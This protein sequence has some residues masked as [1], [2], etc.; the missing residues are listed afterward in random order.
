MMTPTKEVRVRIAPSPTGFFHIG[1]AR[2]ALF[3]WLF[4][5]KNGGKF[6]L[7][8]EDTDL[9]RSDPKYE[10]DIISS[11]KWL[12]LDWDEGP[13]RQSD[14][15][16]IYEKHINKLLQRSLVYYCFCSKEDLEI[17]RE[18]QLSQGIPP[19]YS[20]RC[21]NLSAEEVKERLDKNTPSVLRL[22]VPQV[23]ITFKDII[24][25][26]VT[27]NSKLIGDVVVAKDKR[28][29][30]YNLAVVIDD[31]EMGITHVI[32][33]E[34]HL[35]N[36]PKQII[37]QEALEFNRPKYAHLPLI[38]DPNRSKMSKRFQA[39]AIG[40]Y[41]QDYLP[42]AFLNFLLL[43]GWH[44]EDEKEIF[45]K[46]EMIETFNLERVQKGGAI[47][48]MEKLRWLNSQYI[49]KA[50]SGYLAD[51][52]NLEPTPQNIKI[53]KL[54]QQRMAILNE[55]KDI[56]DFFFDLPEYS[57]EL[58]VWK[59]SSKEK[60]LE[61]LKTIYN[62]GEDFNEEKIKALGEQEGRG[63]VLW[64]LRAALSGKE[65]SPGPFEIMEILGKEESLNRIA[66]AIKRLS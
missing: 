8:I 14:R 6:I 15:A 21:R 23:E 20:G 31:E 2:T 40:D 17:E 55:F 64:P 50:D 42:E 7:R 38:L 10:K 54:A 37:I 45:T 4:A 60:A 49:K 66:L 56:S 47:F 22:K 11:L 27:F 46:E 34:D 16:G 44:P 5:R 9:E 1:T 36:T 32:R 57:P 59:E 24:R 12:G 18:A 52:L 65:A 30:L 26:D 13:I 58:L 61:H 53:I 39:T 33:G 63:A 3:N 25:D 29:P 41:K 43:L 28:T 51:L 35:A 62:L 19:Q 48:D